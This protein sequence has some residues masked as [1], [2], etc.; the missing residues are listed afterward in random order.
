MEVKSV[1]LLSFAPSSTAFLSTDVGGKRSFKHAVS[2]FPISKNTPEHIDTIEKVKRLRGIEVKTQ[3]SSSLGSVHRVPGASG[4][5]RSAWYTS[6]KGCPATVTWISND[7]TR[8]PVNDQI[9]NLLS[10]EKLVSG[11]ATQAAEGKDKE[12]G[13]APAVAVVDD[14]DEMS[15][16]SLDD[17][18]GIDENNIL[19][20]LYPPHAV[21]TQ[22]QKRTQIVLLKEVVRQLRM[23]FNEKFTQL[24]KEKEDIFGSIE[25][26][27]V[28]I[29]AILDD[30]HQK[31]EVASLKMTDLETPGSA[32]RV[33]ASELTSKPYES[34][35]VKAARLREEEERIR[36]ALE[37][38]K[39]DIKGRALDEMMFGTLEVK[40]DVFA[41]ASALQKPGLLF[42]NQSGWTPSL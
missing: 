4:I 11:N 26:R 19:N 35:A 41:E 1:T 32:L 36:K 6:L 34:E 8:W 39:E 22:V 23:R 31:D 30:L 37:S 18:H 27:N 16:N 12:K 21:R 40:R 42:K 3:H 17:D 9:D 7:G 5:H 13:A 28:R 2:S 20:L 24:Y 38:D 25:S 33:D 10:N 15:A 29:R 14:D